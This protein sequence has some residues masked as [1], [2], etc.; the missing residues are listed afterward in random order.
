VLTHLRVDTQLSP[1]PIPI[2]AIPSTLLFSI[3]TSIMAYIHP[4]AWN[5]SSTG[6]SSHQGQVRCL[7]SESAASVAQHVILCLVNPYADSPRPRVYPQAFS[8]LLRMHDVMWACPGITTTHVIGSF[9]LPSPLSAFSL[10]LEG[11][12]QR[13]VQDAP[14][15]SPWLRPRG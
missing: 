6:R 4:D 5:S 8:T 12:P 13:G 11:A 10:H 3:V 14:T 7:S 1:I 2:P 9:P 15:S